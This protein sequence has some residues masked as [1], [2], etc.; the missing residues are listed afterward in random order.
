VPPGKVLKVA[1][2]TTISIPATNKLVID[3]FLVNEG[4]AGSP[5]TLTSSSVTPAAGDWDGLYVSNTLPVDFVSIRYSTNGLVLSNNNNVLTGLT[6]R[7]SSVSA[8]SGASSTGITLQDSQISAIGAN[9]V[10][11]G[12]NASVRNTALSQIGNT[13]LTLGAGALVEDNRIHET[14]DG[15]RVD[16]AAE[17]RRNLVSAATSRAIWVNSTAA[18][19]V[20]HN[21]LL[22]GATGISVNADGNATVEYNTLNNFSAF[23][24]ELKAD[25]SDISNNM[26]NYNLLTNINDGLLGAVAIQASALLSNEGNGFFNTDSDMLGG[27]A[28]TI[29]GPNRLDLTANPLFV[30]PGSLAGGIIPTQGLYDL[31]GSAVDYRLQAT[32]PFLNHS[33][34]GAQAG[35]YNLVRSIT[36]SNLLTSVS[37]KQNEAFLANG[38]VLNSTVNLAAPISDVSAVVANF[39]AIDSGFLPASVV[40]TDNTTDA[41]AP[42]VVVDYTLTNGNTTVDGTGKAHGL[43]VTNSAGHSETLAFTPWTLDNTPPAV[44]VNNLA[45]NE[46]IALNASKLVSVSTTDAAIGGDNLEY[47]LDGGISWTPGDSHFVMMSAGPADGLAAALLV[48]GVNAFDSLDGINVI[49]INPNVFSVNPATKQAFTNAQIPALTSY[50]QGLPDY[51]I[52]AMAVKGNGRSVSAAENTALN[53]ELAR[54]G[55]DTS[56]V[57]NDSFIAIGYKGARNRFSYSEVLAAGSGNPLVV[58]LSQLAGGGMM[59]S[60]IT[61]PSNVAGNFTLMVRSTDFLGNVSV[62][63]SVPYSVQ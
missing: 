36:S 46:I 62:P 5:L 20:H 26:A 57:A 4:T 38:D 35:A 12:A 15:I 2:G 53:V 58:D 49:E 50:L 13:A 45:V 28:V 54:F 59:N 63:V 37:T 18:V 6:I 51:S 42:S 11:L 21:L 41:G 25:A 55:F 48:D 60:T 27:A 29:A 32:S 24:I 10:S 40:L 30:A 23:G 1:S 56:W 31:I 3:G 14:V 8:I 9:A 33:E 19:D 61:L 22:D 44:V 7:D 16:G 43:T 17:V 52:V 39:S 47:S 34:F